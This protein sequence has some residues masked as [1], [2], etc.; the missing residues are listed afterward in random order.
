MVSSK[1]ETAGNQ[2]CQL[3]T[4]GNIKVRVPA[5]LEELFGKYINTKDL[6]FPY[7]QQHIDAALNSKYI[8]DSGQIHYDLRQP[9]SF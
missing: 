7:G 2:I 8:D 5:V 6:N 1:G 3:D 9:P 4:S